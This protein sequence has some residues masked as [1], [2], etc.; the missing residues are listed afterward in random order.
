M[1]V[2][3][4]LIV[5][6]F[7]G[8]SRRPRAWILGVSVIGCA[9]LAADARSVTARTMAGGRSTFS[10]ERYSLQVGQDQ[11]GTLNRLK[12]KALQRMDSALLPHNLSVSAMSACS[13]GSP[14]YIL[15]L[16]RCRTRSLC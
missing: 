11:L 16:V 9:M 10:V 6:A 2:Q 7:L 14:P 3:Q 1:I 12:A 13:C 8:V 15:A 4:S 5:G